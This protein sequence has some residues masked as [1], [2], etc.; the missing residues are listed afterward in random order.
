MTQ[1]LELGAP[2]SEGWPGNSQWPAP[3]LRN[4]WFADLY[5]GFPVK[6]LLP[7]AG[8]LIRW[9]LFAVCCQFLFGGVSR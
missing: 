4:R 7:V 1:N 3:P 5:W 9:L 2:V 6:G 8:R